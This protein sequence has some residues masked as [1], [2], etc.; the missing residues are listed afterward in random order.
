M[1]NFIRTANIK[2]I[3][4]L[5]WLI[6]LSILNTVLIVFGV[7]YGIHQRN[8]AYEKQFEAGRNDSLRG[9]KQDSMLYNVKELESTLDK[10]K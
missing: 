5:F 6:P 9:L 4:N 1:S 10:I 3:Q 8:L 7:F 2:G